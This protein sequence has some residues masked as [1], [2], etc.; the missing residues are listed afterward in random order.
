VLT[1]ELIQRAR[2]PTELRAFVGGIHD[3]VASIPD[4]LL[5]GMQKQGLYKVFLDEIVPLSWFTLARYSND[6]RVQP[7]LGKQA[8]DALVLDRD[9]VTIAKLE[10]TSPH[11]GSAKAGDSRL[12]IN[13]GFGALRACDPGEEV[14]ALAGFIV[15]AAHKK[16]L[17]DYSDCT[18]V[19]ALKTLPPFDSFLS[20]HSAQIDWIVEELRHISFRAKAVFLLVM[21]DRV[22]RI[23]G[24]AHEVH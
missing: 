12:V 5:K 24:K 14:R 3:A 8:Y 1:K 22:I 11:D 10:M 7:V 16:S 4:E 21:P 19:F 20:A 17:K 2:T 6:F 9:G 15:D 13:R 23:V 18:L